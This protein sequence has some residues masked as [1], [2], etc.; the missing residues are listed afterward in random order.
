M[1]TQPFISINRVVTAAALL[2][3]SSSFSARAQ[4]NTPPE[5]S[6]SKTNRSCQLVIDRANPVAPPTVQ[7]YSNQQLTVVIVHPLPFERYFL[8]FT[9]GQATLTPDVTS[10]IV[11]ALI[12]N[13]NHLAVA[14]VRAPAAV[15][16]R[17]CNEPHFKDITGW[18]PATGMAT[19]M[20]TFNDC[21][22]TLATEAV[23]IYKELEPLVAPDSLV[24]SAPKKEPN[25]YQNN[26]CKI[27]GDIN[28]YVTT[29]AIV[30]TKISLI[31]KDT[32]TKYNGDDQDLI[33]QLGSFQKIT[34]AVAADLLGYRQ[35]INDLGAAGY[36]PTS[37]A[38]PTD[39]SSNVCS[40]SGQVMYVIGSQTLYAGISYISKKTHTDATTPDNDTTNWHRI[41][42]SSDARFRG[43]YDPNSADY[44]A[45]NQVT[46]NGRDW[47][48]AADSC[49]ANR[50]AGNG[51]LWTE[52]PAAPQRCDHFAEGFPACLPE[53]GH[54]DDHL[55]TGRPKLSFLLTAGRS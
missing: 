19:A 49:P 48:C 3:L 7:M 29:E 33:T 15:P 43:A 11:Q 5:C 6:L 13:L 9:T 30:S 45:G 25:Y 50:L 52:N 28:V 31:G 27:L 39:S 38:G 14:T 42:Q 40:W 22:A 20:P 2:L 18:P 16:T 4:S 12:P 8:D 46:Y 44:V 10:N 53:H 36:N 24:E 23:Q 47:M 34:D 37:P 54:P 26:R 55:F 1:I 35:R 32:T 21:F 51:D 41:A 17:G